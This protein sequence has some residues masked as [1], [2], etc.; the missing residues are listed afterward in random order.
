MADAERPV[1]VVVRT[2]KMDNLA[3]R[4]PSERAF[5]GAFE[6]GRD[7]G[8]KHFSEGLLRP[9]SHPVFVD[10]VGRL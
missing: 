9:D 10:S 5:P 2:A 4:N 1:V 7:L 6:I 8:R 3:S